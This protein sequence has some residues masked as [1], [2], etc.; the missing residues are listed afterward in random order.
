VFLPKAWRGDAKSV[1]LEV[2]L[3]PYRHEVALRLAEVALDVDAVVALSAPI[4]CW[5]RNVG[6]LL[7]ALRRSGIKATQ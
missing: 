1:F 4:P 7:E 6:E 2:P 3:A 5:G